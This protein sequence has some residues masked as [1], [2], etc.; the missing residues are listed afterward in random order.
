MLKLPECPYCGCK[1]DYGRVKKH[2]HDKTIECRSCKKMMAVTYKKTATKTAVILFLALIVLNTFYISFTK[3]ETIYPNIIFTVL[4][5][6]IFIFLV[7]L[8]VKYHKIAGQETQEKL[9][10]NRHRYKKNK[11]QKTEFNEDPLKGTQF[12]N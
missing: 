11:N 12:D 8:M 4:F 2:I 3:S 5:I 6:F 9:K 7:P 10:K 1:Y